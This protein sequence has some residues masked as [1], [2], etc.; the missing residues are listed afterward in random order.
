M[1]RITRIGTDE[2]AFICGIRAGHS[3]PWSTH[4]G[5]LGTT[6]FISMALAVAAN[7]LVVKL[8]VES[9]KAAVE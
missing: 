1:E 4:F 8:S 3:I 5:L 9:T 7:G 2:N 6:G